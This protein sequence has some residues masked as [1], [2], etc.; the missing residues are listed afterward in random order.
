MT[1]RGAL[2]HQS[3]DQRLLN[4][5][6]C[7][8]STFSILNWQVFVYCLWLTIIP[9]SR[10]EA[11]E[12]CARSLK[13]A[14][15]DRCCKLKSKRTPAFETF[16]EAFSTKL[17]AEINVQGL[18]M[19]NFETQKDPFWW[20]YCFSSFWGERSCSSSSNPKSPMNR[21]PNVE[22]WKEQWK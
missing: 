8:E 14:W 4:I 15:I 9:F 19:L 20:P 17:F 22:Q 13:V 5:L 6:V 21:Y 16:V 1:K 18:S 7:F 3:C 11:N 10:A 2:C 12:N